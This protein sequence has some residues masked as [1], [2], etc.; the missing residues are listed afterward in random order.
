MHMGILGNTTRLFYIT[1]LLN[2]TLVW[3]E[4]LE[5]N[6]AALIRYYTSNRKAKEEAKHCEGMCFCYVVY[7]GQTS[8]YGL[9]VLLRSLQ[10]ELL[11]CK[12]E[13]KPTL[14]GVLNGSGCHPE[15]QVELLYQYLRLV[16]T[17][18]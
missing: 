13:K 11:I 2:V 6:M 4:S 9:C 15:W 14:V 5:T 12:Y 3:V 8:Y 10:Y 1:L 18:R 16:M 17:D 7:Y